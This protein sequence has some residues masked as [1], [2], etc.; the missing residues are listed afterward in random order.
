MAVFYRAKAAEGFPDDLLQTI[1]RTVH[2]SY[3]ADVRPS[4]TDAA[5]PFD[6]LFYDN[7]VADPAAYFELLKERYPDV[8]VHIPLKHTWVDGP[9]TVIIAELAPKRFVSFVELPKGLFYMEGTVLTTGT[10]RAIFDFTTFWHRAA[11]TGR[12]YTHVGD[13]LANVHASTVPPEEFYYLLDHFGTRRI[14]QTLHGVLAPFTDV[15]RLVQG[16]PRATRSLARIVP[17][18]QAIERPGRQRVGLT[19]L[20]FRVAA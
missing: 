12:V 10:G 3:F 19:T 8:K 17:W 2:A 20:T 5:S 1:A 9:Y 7:E 11:Y 13:Y 16:T 14:D 18:F 4:I 15:Y 6:R